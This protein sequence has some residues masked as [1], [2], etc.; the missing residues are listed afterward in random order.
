MFIKPMLEDFES[1]IYES[2][3]ADMDTVEE[4]LPTVICPPLIDIPGAEKPL[5]LIAIF[6]VWKALACA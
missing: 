6:Q 1:L 4:V 2:L 3:P 5:L